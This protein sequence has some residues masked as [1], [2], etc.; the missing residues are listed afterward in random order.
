MKNLLKFS[1]VLVMASL[2]FTGCNCF[3]KMAK[4][5]SD[6]TIACQPEVL[7]LN[8]GT[9]PADITVTFPEKY[10]NKKAILKVTPVLTFKGGEVTATPRYLQ[11]TKIDDNYPVVEKNGGV[12]NMHVE[13]PYD[14]RMDAGVKLELRAEIKCKNSDEFVAVNLSTGKPLEEGESVAGSGIVV[15]GGLNLLQ[16]DFDYASAMATA[17]NNYKRVL[18]YVD[19]ADI[20]YAINDSKINKRALKKNESVAAFQE[21]VEQTMKNDRATQHIAVKGYASPDGPETFNDKLSSARSQ[22]GKKALAEML[23]DT[24]LEID[25]AAYGEDW[26]GFKELVEKS[27]IK[28]KDL[29]LQVLSLYSTS[30]QRESE[31][32]NMSAVFNEL[33]SEIL[34][35]LR[36]AQLVNTMDVEGKTDAEIMALVNSKKYGELTN[37]ELLY[38]AESLVK[39]NAQK[40]D[41]LAYTAKQYNDA[42][43]YN[44]LGVAQAA[45]GNQASALKAFEQAMKTG[46]S[47][48][49]LNKNLAL[50][51]LA[52]GNVAEAK[53]Y[54]QSADAE[55]KAAV[56]AAEGKYDQAAK[57]LTGY[58]AAIAYVMNNDLNAA[59]KAI[60]A[61]NS[62]DADYLRAVI[63]SKSGDLKTAE[64]QLKSAIAK[65]SSLAKKA[66][67]DVNLA[68]LKKSGFKF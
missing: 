10:F 46:G 16:K 5:A 26:D 34:P 18:T 58:N 62:A 17:A 9:I 21:N 66:L 64:A 31:I 28:D 32:K 51:N 39:N 4:N 50:A 29:I 60:A 56:A 8:N 38:A 48:A 7:A 30:A 24:G 68:N 61:D 6:V 42:R 47:D 19:K 36:R 23:K 43:A 57:N 63:A 15:A 45:E 41:V 55:T 53:K 20:K 22:S 27:D 52:N 54:A 59:K 44:N 14:A 13:F 40:I 2:A 12:Y 37:E 1:M 3:K 33:K 11:G 49:G 65:D 35:E 67:N 25:A